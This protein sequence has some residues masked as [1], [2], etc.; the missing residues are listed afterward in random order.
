MNPPKAM[1]RCAPDRRG[2]RQDVCF[3]ESPRACVVLAKRRSGSKLSAFSLLTTRRPRRASPAPGSH[4]VLP[5]GARRVYHT[6][7]AVKGLGTLP[8]VPPTGRKAGPVVA[9]SATRAST[10]R[11]CWRTAIADLFQVAERPA[12]LPLAD[13]AV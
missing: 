7:Q 8:T 9:G 6:R 1:A 3:M 2:A 4:A 12:R 10:R 5:A 13:R 11:R